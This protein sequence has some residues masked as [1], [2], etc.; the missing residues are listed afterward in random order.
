MSPTTTRREFLKTTASLSLAAAMP[1]LATDDAKALTSESNIRKAIMWNTIGLKGSVLEVM[2]AVKQAGFDGVEMMSHMNQEEVL[3]ARDETGLEIASVCGSRHGSNL[4]SSPDESVRT[5]GLRA[6]QQTLR[7]AKAYG[8]ASILLVPGAVRNGTTYE[9]CWL[10]SIAEIRKAIPLAQELGV[11][12]SIENVWNNFITKEDEAARYLDEINNSWVGWHFDCGNVIRY[13]DPIAWIKKLGA[14]INR[15]H[16]KEYSL[17]RA[18]RTGN[19]RRGFD[20]PLL[21]GANN[22]QGIMKAILATSYKGWAI[23]EQP[24]GDTVEGLKDLAIRLQKI[25]SLN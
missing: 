10:R 21:E 22:W 18:M 7:D 6:L 15:Y 14:R 23:T 17:D 9:E 8:A 19:V 25:L 1:A 5:E 24:G 4:L 2:K 20:A 16:I 3:K 13:G 12:I 11:K